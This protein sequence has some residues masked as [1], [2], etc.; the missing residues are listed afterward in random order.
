[1]IEEFI[2]ANGYHNIAFYVNKKTN[3][4]SALESV[5]VSNSKKINLEY[6]QQIH[7]GFKLKVNDNLSIFA[8]FTSQACTQIFFDNTIIL[9]MKNVC[10]SNPIN[11]NIFQ[12][13]NRCIFINDKQFSKYF[14]VL[15]DVKYA[16][17]YTLD[18]LNK[19]FLDPNLC[20]SAQKALNS[21]LHTEQFIFR[22][23]ENEYRMQSQKNTMFGYKNDY[24]IE[25]YHY[26]KT[27]PE[28]PI[29]LRP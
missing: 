25:T 8:L 9:S 16:P 2:S 28:S 29:S 27:K 17:N 11:S 15:D 19:K 1:M 10:I 20:D 22:N 12:Y 6:H 21:V 5:F 23:W 26:S 3:Y 24:I 4:I 18:P 13:C 7:A 14:H